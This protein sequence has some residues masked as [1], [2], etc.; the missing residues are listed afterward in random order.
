[1]PHVAANL[2]APHEEVER[3]HPL[4]CAQPR[5]ARK[6]VQV[7]DEPLHEVLEARIL[8]LRVDADRVGRDVVDRQIQQLRCLVRHVCCFFSGSIA[9]FPLLQFESLEIARD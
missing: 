7:R 9:A 8:A 5:L 6:V 2:P 1:M 3:R 4:V